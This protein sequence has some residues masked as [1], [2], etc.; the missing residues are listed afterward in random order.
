MVGFPRTVSL[1]Q[2][3]TKG[4]DKL[5][6]RYLHDLTALANEIQILRSS[7]AQFLGIS[8]PQYLILMHV[9]QHQSGDP[10]TITSVAEVLRVSRSHVT[11][12]TNAL[13]ALGFMQRLP[14]PKDGRSQVLQTT[15]KAD[16][17]IQKLAPLLVHVNDTLFATL[18][19]ADFR[20]MARGTA[21][22]LDETA[23][24]RA[25]LSALLT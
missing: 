17:E 15:P 16:G 6:R 14:H 7:F 19:S 21:L 9:A 20:S 22:V 11:R 25:R 12:E 10:Q 4:S 2:I 23:K 24:A 18:E 8:P 1:S 3:L 5:M 13:V